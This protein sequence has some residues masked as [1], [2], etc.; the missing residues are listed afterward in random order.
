MR[1]KRVS[2]IL[3]LFFLLWVFSRPLSSVLLWIYQGTG[4]QLHKFAGNVREVKKDA[5]NLL[6][7]E[8]QLE[9]AEER[10][11]ELELENSTLKTKTAELESQTAQLNYATKFQYTL[12]A[13]QVIGRSPDTWHRQVIINKGRRH[14]LRV[15]Q[16]V[17]SDKSIIGQ[18]GKVGNDTA[19]VQLT[20]NRDWKM[21]IKIKRSGQ[22]AVLVGDYPA[23]A[24]LEL[25]PMDSDI[26]IGDW[27]LSSGICVDSSDCPY[28]PDMLVG[29]V[30]EVKH[31]PNQVDLTVKVA[32][33]DDLRAL[34][35]VYI[36][37]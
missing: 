5:L 7:A 27:V 31:D 22:F 4:A 9:K 34:R 3:I 29:Q 13:A 10:L 20:Q 37:R 14:G 24:H 16:G 2:S 18:I 6:S 35:E 11:K 23:T 17:I 25:I 15:G 21:G 12:T 8:E 32:L 36:I 33:I 30:V 19:I 26:E 1:F 28:P